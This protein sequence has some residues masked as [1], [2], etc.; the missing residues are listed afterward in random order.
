MSQAVQTVDQK[1]E[2]AISPSLLLGIQEAR[3]TFLPSKSSS[4]TQHSTLNPPE[5]TQ[6]AI[7]YLQEFDVQY[8]DYKW[9]GFGQLGVSLSTSSPH[10]AECTVNLR[11]NNVNERQWEGGVSGLVMF[12]GKGK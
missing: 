1:A 5:G 4:Q 12:F 8:T 7:I 9:Y 3:F 11:D 6:E 10:R 2:A